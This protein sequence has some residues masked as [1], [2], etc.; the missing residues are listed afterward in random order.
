MRDKEVNEQLKAQGWTVFRFWET[1]ITKES[2]K[3]LNRILNYMNAKTKASDKI[4]ITQMCGGNKVSMQMYGPHSLNEDGTIIPFEK[5][6]FA[7]IGGKIS[8]LNILQYVNFIN[9]KSIGRIMYTQ[10]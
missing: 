6:L 3:C 7:G 1:E 8:T 2:D 10:N 5:Y 4:A 9:N